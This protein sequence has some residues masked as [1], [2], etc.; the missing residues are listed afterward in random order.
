MKVEPHGIAVADSLC[1]CVDSWLSSPKESKKEN[2]Q[3]LC[4]NGRSAG[5][6]AISLD[7]AL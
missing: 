4:P 5:L 2:R 6:Q 7:D 1:G 3:T